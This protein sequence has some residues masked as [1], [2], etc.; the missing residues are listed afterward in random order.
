MR[1]SIPLAAALLLTCPAA[2]PARPAYKLALIDLVGD[3][4]PAKLRDCRT[5]HVPLQKGDD[6][7]DRPHNAFGK[8]LKALRPEL[9]KAGKPHEISDRI[10]A[11]LDEDSDGDGVSNGLEL[12]SGHNPGEKSDA[13][14]PGEL[15]AARK[16]LAAWL[17]AR[18]AAYDWRPFQP[19]SRPAVPTVKRAAWGRNPIDAFVAAEHERRSLEPR[20]EAAKHVLLRRVTIDL[21][22]LPPTPEE[23]RAFLADVSPD[24]YER[25]VDRL[26][27]SPRYGER[28]GRHWMD[29]WRYSDWAGY[30]AEVRDSQKHVWRWRDWIVE[31]LNAGKGY[32]RMVTE[33]L[34][35]DELSP[36]DPDALRATGFLARNWYRFNR[37]VWLDRAVEHTAKAFLGVTL[38]C[39]R[40]HDHFFD[41]IAMEEYY[42]FR[43][44]FEPHL[45]R[46]DR[47]PGE[48]DV[49]RDG[50]ARVYDAQ[51]AVPTYLFERG[52]EARPD[53]S[54]SIAPAVP[55]ALGGSF[56]VTPVKL[57]REAIQPDRREFVVRE[58][59][60][61]SKAAIAQS[62]EAVA[63]AGRQALIAFAPRPAS[64][65]AAV[66]WAV[67]A[68]RGGDGLRVAQLE[69]KLALARHAALEAVLAAE[70][71]EDGSAREKRDQAARAAAKAQRDAA[72]IEAR[73]NLALAELA[74]WT[75]SGKN[76][77]PAAQRLAGAQKALAAAEAVAKQPATAAYVKRA[78]VSFPDTSTGRRLALAKWITDDRNPLAA[79]V[80]VNHVWLRHFGQ[81]LVATEFDFGRNGQR[82]TH[83][84]L[85]DWLAAEFMA[86]GWDLKRLHRL[87][88]TSSA[89]RMDSTATKEMLAK[90]PDNRFLWRMNARRMEGEAVRDSLLAVAGRLDE[91]RGGPDLDH[92]SG[93]SV[94]RRS[95]YFRH[96]AEKQMEFLLLFDP[97]SVN[98]CYKRSESIIPQQAL[99]LSNSSLALGLSRLLARDLAKAAE[100]PDAFVRLAFERI[101]CRAPTP[102]ERE[103]CLEFLDEQAKLLSEPKKLTPFGSGALSATPPSGDPRL[104]A[105]ENLVHVLFN[106]HEFVTIR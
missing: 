80:A 33:M 26:L 94:P 43:A 91:S 28:W 25:V 7:T 21:T 42:A 74:H 1:A 51:P 65:L 22:G 87:I 69:Q 60:A 41:P 53:K 68:Q 27:S 85:L 79:R 23:L 34:A 45:V 10:L 90:D 66:P 50:L 3:A 47:V 2:A 18:R 36:T 57:P 59:V 63:A 13:P 24:A 48:K 11:A 71:L 106:H 54:K 99:A 35:A 9:R 89:Y 104:R 86:T 31:S 29:V 100:K 102:A 92:R 49:E 20:P 72:L 73:R 55:S 105:R 14:S 95:L 38:N 4:L 30:G 16:K 5:C 67:L 76:R 12:F 8:R 101:L 56:R 93:E 39:A 75:S 6:E 19:V 97:A 61:A 84:A 81:G 88:V 62:D 17:A 15:P 103:A 44:I 32:D 40:C 58:T 83:P 46:V 98:E 96:A 77:P 78:A 52:D 37:N 70:K 64:A 82:P